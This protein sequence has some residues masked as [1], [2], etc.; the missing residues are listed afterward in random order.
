MLIKLNAK[1]RYT[2]E[3]C[4]EDAGVFAYWRGVVVDGVYKKILDYHGPTTSNDEDESA[5]HAKSKG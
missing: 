2:I 5:A 4:L 1:I 3:A